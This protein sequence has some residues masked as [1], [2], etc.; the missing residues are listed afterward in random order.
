MAE[1]MS[2]QKSIQ[3]VSWLLL[4]A[5]IQVYIEKKGKSEAEQYL[6][7]TCNLVKNTVSKFKVI[8]KVSSKPVSLAPLKRNIALNW[9]KRKGV[10][11][12]KAL[13]TEVIM[14][15]I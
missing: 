9:D 8:D 7:K 15:R 5:L 2:R 11:P 3:V 12:S 6:K 10:H 4:S 1:E 14:K 13:S